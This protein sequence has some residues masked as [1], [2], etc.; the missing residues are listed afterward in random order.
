MAGHLLRLRY[1]SRRSPLLRPVT[2]RLQPPILWYR[3]ESKGSG[4]RH[5]VEERAPSTAEAFKRVAEEKE[6]LKRVEEEMARRGDETRTV[7]KAPEAAEFEAISAGDAD[8]NIESGR[9][10]KV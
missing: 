10:E 1:N 9:R 8:N 4:G 6:Q 2:A 5:G 7:K 3:E